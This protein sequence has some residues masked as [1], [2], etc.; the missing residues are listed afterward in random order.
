MKRTL[1]TLAIAAL[2]V[3]SIPSLPANAFPWFQFVRELFGSGGASTAPT[4]GGTN[5]ALPYVL[6]PR[7]SKIADPRPLLRWNPVAEASRYTVTLRG[8]DGIVWQETVSGQTALR[9]PGE[10][11]LLPNVD[12]V[13]SV[14]TDTGVSSVQE[15]VPGLAFS[16][17]EATAQTAVTAALADVGTAQ[18]EASWLAQADVLQSYQ[19]LTAAIALLEAAPPSVAVSRRLGELYLQTQLALQAKPQFEQALALAKAAGD[20]R[21]Q[22]DLNVF[23]GYVA[24]ELR[25]PYPALARLEQAQ[26]LYEQAGLTQEAD[27]VAQWL[28]SI[29]R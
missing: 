10:P 4:R 9:Y 27:A 19:L 26:T 6:S 11:P 12:Y 15:A 22:A 24:L 20:V 21:S 14:S 2:A 13:L 17:I 7:R 25:Q 3:L 23:L 16:L 1:V 29:S 5:P 28:A 18:D 8:P